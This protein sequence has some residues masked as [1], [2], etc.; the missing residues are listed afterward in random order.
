MKKIEREP[1][2]RDEYIKEFDRIAKGGGSNDPKLEEIIETIRQEVIEEV[3]E[4]IKKI[5]KVEDVDSSIWELIKREYVLSELSQ[6][7]PKAEKGTK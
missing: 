2:Y 4:L 1:K 6:L 3:K 7:R 5:P